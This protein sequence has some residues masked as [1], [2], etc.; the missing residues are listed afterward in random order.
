MLAIV[1]LLWI[2]FVVGIAAS[3]VLGIRSAAR[4]AGF[5][6]DEVHRIMRVVVPVLGGWL[7]LLGVLA[8]FG[9]FTNFGA[10]PPRLLLAVVGAMILFAVVGRSRTFVRL[11]PAIPRSWPIALQTMRL[12]I[13]LGLWALCAL[14]KLPEHLTF[15]GRNFDVLVGITAPAMAF[16]IARAWV[17][18]RAILAW[19]VA[20][21]G[22]LAN[23][24]FMAITSAPGPLKLDWPGVPNE[25]VAAF[26]FV[27]L[28]G[29]L[30]PLALFTTITSL[31]QLRLGKSPAEPS[32]TGR[33][34]AMTAPR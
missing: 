22:L 12:P 6:A 9:F 26:P 20:S 21:L 24:V 2:A 8:G 33:A 18:A 13:E 28:P 19:N 7:G 14:G 32:R 29:F 15:E 11:L 34:R 1:S 4:R 27:W 5:P 30:V 3:V 23:I 10:R 31:R 25:I 16:A 17:G